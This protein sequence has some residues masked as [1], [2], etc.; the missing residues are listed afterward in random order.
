M[1]KDRFIDERDELSKLENSVLLTTRG[2]M[3]KVEDKYGNVLFEP[4]EVTNFS[5][6]GKKIFIT[7]YDT[8]KYPS[9]ETKLD[10]Y[11]NGIS[12]LRPKFKVSLIRLDYKNNEVYTVEYKKCRLNSYHGKNFNY[13][14]N[15]LHQWYLEM[16][17][18]TKSIVN[19]TEDNNEMYSMECAAENRRKNASIL[20]YTNEMLKDAAENVSQSKKIGKSKKEMVIKELNNDVKYNEEHARKVLGYNISYGKMDEMER[21][22]VNKLR[23]VEE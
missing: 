15:E 4:H 7:V 11:L 22:I 3:V 19:E 5:V 21:E 14:T 9:I 10:C 12:F 18:S 17:Y 13:K 6:D 20:Q 8:L 2:F 23:E 1:K 16:R